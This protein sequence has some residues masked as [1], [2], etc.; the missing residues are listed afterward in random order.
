MP[1]IELIEMIETKYQLKGATMDK[2]LTENALKPP[3]F[4]D[5]EIDLFL[6]RRV[7][8]RCYGDLEKRNAPNYSA[9]NHEYEAYCPECG[10]A[11][12]YATVSKG[13][14]E[15]LGQAALVQMN[16]VQHN[17]RDL[18]PNPHKGKS[19]SQLLAELGY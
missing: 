5:G 16:E 2:K 14:A 15:K 8:A 18:F 3:T 10:N 6:R 1:N 19:Q 11:W 4:Q 13:Y 17:L 7:C 9:H 12:N